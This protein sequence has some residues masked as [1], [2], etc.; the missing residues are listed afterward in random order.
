MTQHLDNRA[1][2]KP[3]LISRLRRLLSPKNPNEIWK[4]TTRYAKGEKQTE[5][6]VKYVAS[7][8]PPPMPELGQ[9]HWGRG[10][11]ISVEAEKISP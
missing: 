6:F 10:V 11:L 1:L 3:P 5:P 4:I 2:F 7:N 9:A 8:G